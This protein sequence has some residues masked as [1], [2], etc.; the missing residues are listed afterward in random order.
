MHCQDVVLFFGMPHTNGKGSANLLLM[1]YPQ[2]FAQPTGETSHDSTFFIGRRSCPAFRIASPV[3]PEAWRPCIGQRGTAVPPWST[4]WFLHRPRWTRSTMTAVAP[5]GFSGR[6]WGGTDEVTG[7][8]LYIGR[9]CS[10][11]ALGCWHVLA[12]ERSLS[13]ELGWASW[14]SGN[15]HHQTWR[16]YDVESAWKRVVLNVDWIWNFWSLWSQ[17]RFKLKLI[18]TIVWIMHKQGLGIPAIVG[19][20]YGP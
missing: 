17:F 1:T 5:E 4:S 2:I 6:L 3:A 15:R 13:F 11:F 10:F 18:A 20:G 16:T 7:R 14:N 12:V 9:W 8:G 19:N